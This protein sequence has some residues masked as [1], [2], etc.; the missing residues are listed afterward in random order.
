MSSHPSD[1]LRV[2]VELIKEARTQGIVE[3]QYKDL[4]VRFSPQVQQGQ[5]GPAAFSPAMPVRATAPTWN[6]TI[7]VPVPKDDE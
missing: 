2:M 5:A 6:T 1:E 7:T 4:K 3:L